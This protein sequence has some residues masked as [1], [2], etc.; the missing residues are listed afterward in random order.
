MNN[1]I[2]VLSIKKL[3]TDNLLFGSIGDRLIS[4][5]F[6]PRLN[7]GTK[8]IRDASFVFLIW[9]SRR[10]Q[11]MNS[12]WTI[13]ILHMFNHCRIQ[14]DTRWTWT[15]SH[16]SFSI[17]HDEMNMKIFMFMFK[18]F[19]FLQICSFFLNISHV[20]VRRK[21]NFQNIH[22]FDEKCIRPCMKKTWTF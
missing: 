8:S 5:M 9:L 10:C 18:F 7:S 21:L 3:L 12:Y 14:R 19:H 20:H 22:E 1:R 16:M 6:I 2:F 13:R 15:F 4:S 11:I 17:V